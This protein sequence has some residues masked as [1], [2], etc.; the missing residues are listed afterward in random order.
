MATID[1]MVPQLDHPA[2]S[3]ES[4]KVRLNKPNSH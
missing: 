2:D 3:A 1:E 4:A